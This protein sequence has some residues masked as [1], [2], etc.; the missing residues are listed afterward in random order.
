MQTKS[1]ICNAVTALGALLVLFSID[2]NLAKAQPAAL[3]NNPEFRPAL[4]ASIDSAYNFQFKGSQNELKTWKQKYP[5][6]PL[7]NFWDGFILWWK[8]LPDLEDHSHDDDF[9]NTMKKAS[10]EASQILKKYPNHVD[11]IMIQSA[12]LGYMARMYANRRQWVDAMQVGR[13]ALNAFERLKTVDPTMSD[14]PFGDGLYSYY[15]A[16]IPETY[17]VVK[18]ISWMLPDGNKKEGIKGL[19]KAADNGLLTKGEAL[20][21]LANIYLNYEGQPDQAIQYLRQLTRRYPRNNFYAR[22]L[23]HAYIQADQLLKARMLV[24]KL[25]KEWNFEEDPL[26]RVMK[27]E[28]YALTAKIYHK[29]DQK[30]AMD[31]AMTVDSLRSHLNGGY[32]RTMQQMAGYYRGNILYKQQKTKKARKILDTISSVDEESQYSKKAKQL[33]KEIKKG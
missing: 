19:K 13:S 4:L 25:V 16:Y 10:Y 1:T 12:S 32:N 2:V 14:I 5:D 11:A 20:Y 23:I 15:M 17:P 18:S 7:W 24:D 6:H 8:M 27:E 30:R 21:F 33:L 26:G 31:A 22:A 9:F 29:K 3:I 28:L